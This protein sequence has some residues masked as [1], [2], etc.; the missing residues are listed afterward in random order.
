MKDWD[1][2]PTDWSN[3]EHWTIRRY[4][5]T[6][7]RYMLTARHESGYQLKEY[8]DIGV[9]DGA[10]QR[11]NLIFE[12]LQDYW[13]QSGESSIRIRRTRLQ[14]DLCVYEVSQKTYNEYTDKY[15]DV[16]RSAVLIIGSKVLTADA[17]HN[18]QNYTFHFS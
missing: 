13:V 7:T 10:T 9:W 2:A 3:Y 15:T 12:H 5:D 18:K 8:L 6:R 11:E 17:K 16:A 1:S 4:W 14:Q